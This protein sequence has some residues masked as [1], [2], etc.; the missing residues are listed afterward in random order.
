MTSPDHD[1]WKE[2]VIQNYANIKLNFIEEVSVKYQII[3][4]LY[5]FQAI[6]QISFHR[7]FMICFDSEKQSSLEDIR[8]WF[9]IMLVGCGQKPWRKQGRK[10]AIVQSRLSLCES[11]WQRRETPLPISALKD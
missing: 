11:M 8:Q 7:H 6:V 2:R 10:W 4:N 1:A 3:L 5:I 9:N